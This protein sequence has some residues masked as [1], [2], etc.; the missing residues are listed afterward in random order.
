MFNEDTERCPLVHTQYGLSGCAVEPASSGRG[1]CQDAF[2][3]TIGIVAIFDQGADAAGLV[4][5]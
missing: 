3:M 5:N 4:E 2:F 1:G